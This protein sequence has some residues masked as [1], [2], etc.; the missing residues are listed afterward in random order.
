MRTQA[1]CNVVKPAT[2]MAFLVR[3][4]NRS[5]GHIWT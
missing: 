2:V 4:G 1:M 5:E 3:A